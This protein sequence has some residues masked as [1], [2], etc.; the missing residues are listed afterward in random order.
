MA[1]NLYAA[2]ERPHALAGMP[3]IA[4]TLLRVFAALLVMQHGAQ[5]LFDLFGGFGG[6]GARAPLVSM[7]GVAG[8]IELV[9]GLL[10]A[11]GLFTRP[12][13]LVLSGE[14]AAAYFIGHAPRGFWP[15][16]NGGEPAALLSF[17]FLLFAAL[18]SGPYSIDVRRTGRRRR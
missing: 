10:V 4:L 8:V 14:L 16:Q 12:A 7:Y 6:A 2:A 9:G 18:G 5:K 3:G 1:R 17:V 13:A 15:L 11:L